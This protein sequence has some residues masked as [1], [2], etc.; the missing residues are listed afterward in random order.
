MS[1]A[2]PSA[3]QRMYQEWRK[4][5]M[6]SRMAAPPEQWR[7]YAVEVPSAGKSTLHAWFLNQARVRQW[8][9]PRH[10][11][12]LSMK[13]WE[14]FNKD[15]EL[16]Y[17]FHRNQLDDDLDGLVN[18]AAMDAKNSGAKWAKF[19]DELVA[20]ALEAGT[21]ALCWDGQY[22]F[23]TDH[24][25]DPDSVSTSNTFDNDR[26][27]ALNHANY[28]TVLQ[29]FKDFRSVD[30][31][32]VGDAGSY[33][34]M[35]PTALEL[36]A[37][38]IL[39][40]QYITPATAFILATTTGASPNPFVGSAR[41][42]VNRY[43]TDTTRWYLFASDGILKPLMLQRRTGIETFETDESSEI[44]YNEGIYRFGSNA[45]LNVSYALPQFAITSKP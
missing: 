11:N 42:V 22:F 15:Y 3:V 37:R 44:Y 6:T 2:V 35:V 26:A 25:I 45:R 19:E 5:L 18:D 38:S 40:D 43:L 4:D 30:N 29:A 27:L 10:Y 20:T 23:D 17:Q 28:G 9:G 39:N 12:N 13:S 36:T 31:Y 41:L 8:V 33:V 34:L 32:P 21:S 1:I 24:P 14:V 16:S 7:D